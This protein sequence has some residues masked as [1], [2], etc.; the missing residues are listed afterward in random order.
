M[1]KTKKLQKKRN[2]KGQF[3][4]TTVEK[5]KKGQSQKRKASGSAKKKN[6]KNSK[7]L[8]GLNIC[9]LKKP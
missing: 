6:G 2:K 3:V 8:L 1:G 5:K 4:R 9:L 7:R